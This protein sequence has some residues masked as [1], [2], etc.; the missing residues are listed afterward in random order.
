MT[1]PELDRHDRLP[2]LKHNI[3]PTPSL[4]LA[5]ALVTLALDMQ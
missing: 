4:T 3:V 1:A 5:S 2:I